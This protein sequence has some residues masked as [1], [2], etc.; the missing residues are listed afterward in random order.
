MN[1]NKN[2]MKETVTENVVRLYEVEGNT[3]PVLKLP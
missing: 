1:E 2:L 3:V